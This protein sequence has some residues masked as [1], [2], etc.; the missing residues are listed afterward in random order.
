VDDE[1]NLDR[2]MDLLNDTPEDTPVFFD[3]A[4]RPRWAGW[5]YLGDLA[6]DDASHASTNTTWTLPIHEAS[7]TVGFDG[8]AAQ[9]KP[10]T[11]GLI[12]WSAGTAAPAV[13]P[14][15]ALLSGTASAQ[16][17]ASVFL[18]ESDAATDPSVDTTAFTTGDKVSVAGWMTLTGFSDLSANQ[19]MGV[20]IGSATAAID[21]TT[22]AQNHIVLGADS[23]GAVYL[24]TANGTSVTS[25]SMGYTAV[26]GTRFKFR[27]DYTVGSTVSA[28][29]ND[30]TTIP[31][32]TTLPTFVNTLHAGWG[33]SG[34]VATKSVNAQAVAFKFTPAA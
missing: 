1:D 20:R 23:T 4:Q 15:G 30:T 22:T 17:I 7:M 8:T 14:R 19:L 32:S 6:G 12:V 10:T 27:I 31:V 3:S 26:S 2:L 9:S 16:N 5:Y 13:S 24:I 34:T 11:E 18:G 28:I 21:K 25:T 29:I 33:T